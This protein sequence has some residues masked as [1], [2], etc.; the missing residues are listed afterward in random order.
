M[1]RLLG[2]ALPQSTPRPPPSGQIGRTL[3]S[4][5]GLTTTNDQRNHNADIPGGS[6]WPSGGNRVQAFG[7]RGSRFRSIGDQ[8]GTGNLASQAVPERHTTLCGL[9]VR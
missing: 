3:I 8:S 9:S 2:A 6:G 5:D 7:Q 4:P 1:L